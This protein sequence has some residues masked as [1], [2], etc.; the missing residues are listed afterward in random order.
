MPKIY[1]FPEKY[2]AK[3][4]R[5]LAK[6]GYSL[7]QPSKIAECV[8]SLSHFYQEGGRE[9]PWSKTQSQVAYL[10]YFFPL[11]YVRHLK[12]LDEAKSHIPKNTTAPVLDFG[13]GLGSSRLAL[14]DSD[15]ITPQ[16]PYTAIEKS[17]AA[18]ELY[19]FLESSPILQWTAAYDS[20]PNSRSWGVMSYSLNELATLPRWVSQLDTVLIVEPSTQK[21]GRNL[22][23]LRSTFMEAQ[24]EILAPC[25]HREA[26]PLLT[27][28]KTDWCHDRIHWEQPAWFSAIEAQLPIKNNTLTYSYLLLS[29]SSQ[30][31]NSNEGRV[32]SDELHEKGKTR[33]LYCRNSEREYLSWLE[34]AG[35]APQ[36]KR[37]D[38]PQV[39]VTEKK[40][41][42]LRFTLS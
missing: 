5:A 4:E 20:T 18:K 39:R 31:K 24:F 34:R 41:N 8:L 30:N 22:M 36:I 33:W 6:L 2:Q 37:G 38:L 35:P 27:H 15:W 19:G 32:V 11:N 17:G 26:C 13:F 10:S 7:N 29:K 1:S 16:T 40:G 28:S 9:T 3:I 14:L 12:I 21:I 42:E 23:A 25:T